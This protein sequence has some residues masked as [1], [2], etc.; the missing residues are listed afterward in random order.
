MADRKIT[1]LTLRT[2]ACIFLSSLFLF[3]AAPGISTLAQT[4]PPNPEEPAKPK[5]EATDNAPAQRTQ[6]NLLG[7]TDASSG[8]SRRNENVQFN[9]IDNNALRELNLRIGASA[10]LVQEFRAER[11]FFGSEYGVPSPPPVHLPSAKTAGI[12]GSL[13]ETHNNS[14]FSARSFFQVGGV[15]PARENNYGFNVGAPLWR[16]GRSYLF[17]EGSQQKV[18]GVVNG[19]VLVPKADERTPLATDPALRRMIE[20]FLA[21]YPRELPNRTDIDPRALNTNAPQRIDTNAASAR[22]DHQLNKRDRLSLRYAFTGQ[23]VLPFQ[24][25]AGQNPD[26]F[27]K[28]HNGRIT[29]NR[30]WSAA[31]TADFSIG[32]DRITSLL[33]PEKN[34]V[35]PTVSFGGAITGLGP[36][37]PIP[38]NRA[39]NHFRYAGAVVHMR[40]GH[41][42]SLGA[43]LTR[44]QINGSE[45]DG[46]RGILG[47][48]NDRE[49]DAITN[50]RLGIANQYTLAIGNTHRG[51][52]NW[53]ATGYAGDSWRASSTLQINYG[54]RYQVVT[55]PSEVNDLN[56]FPFACDCNNIGP[57]FGLAWRAPERLG[58]IR[59]NYGLHYGQIFAVTYGQIR[60]NPPGSRRLFVGNPNLLNPLGN[61]NPNNLP[62]GTPASVFDFSPDFVTP[63]AHQ[64]NL[65]WEPTPARRVKLQL[66]YV[67]S[68]A[69][70]LFQ[71]WFGNRG[72]IAVDA[73]PGNINQRRPDATVLERYTFLNA[74]RGW[75]D[76]AR[77]SVILNEWRG[78]SVD[79]S[80]WFSKSLDLGHDYTNTLS[81][82]DGRVS[83]SQTEFEVQR[84]LKARSGFDQP[85]AFLT[86]A[87]WQMPKFSAQPAWLRGT[88]GAWNFSAVTLLK[89]GTPFT[90]ESG[91]DAPNFGNV[92]GQSG[93]RPNLLDLSVLGRA[94][95]NPDSSAR[96]LPRAAFAFIRPG[97]AAGSLGRNTFRRGR[98]ANVNAALAR[99]WTIQS[100]TSITF[101]AESLNFLNT[102]QFA[103]PTR[104][105]A[106]PSFGRITNTLNDGRTFRFTLR[107]NF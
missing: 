5:P 41:R 27:T 31:T 42:F 76:A 104:E 9:L 92:D 60:L 37:P 24:F 53:V 77:V 68:R 25:V 2:P 65:S 75:Y 15:K 36:A 89:N 99:S 101:R 94:I 57:Q 23:N 88:L 90:V 70:K 35:G 86:R 32:F 6:L 4:T 100:R 14:V 13:F 61:L 54:L 18:R 51:F 45:P 59:A 63:Y 69:H 55:R 44:T 38:I 21:A 16:A 11:N 47:F 48:V 107:V 105:L 91:S 72:R 85:H 10:T 102:P 29:W 73:A 46:D 96:L 79:A 84:D 19:N 3:G 83:R 64:Y 95:G 22:L 82:S 8:E 1:N 67:G 34:A 28:S 40:S 103:E 39:L 56:R 98:I 20:R 12:H 58:V 33:R 74:S 26:T 106:S 93:D 87:S 80:Y 71:M 30:V 7:Q 66:G 97:E 52:R 49:R 78:V 17:V 50:L 62:P 43:E 81:G